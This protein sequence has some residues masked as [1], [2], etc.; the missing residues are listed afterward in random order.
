MSAQANNLSGRERL[1]RR[2]LAGAAAILMGVSLVFTGST[3][4]H[5]IDLLKARESAREYARRVRDNSGGKYLHYS[6][7]CRAM[8]PGHNH[9]VSCVIDYQNAKDKAAGVYTCRE[10]IKIYMFPHSVG[11]NYTL[12]G[13]HSSNNNCGGYFVKYQKMG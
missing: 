2:V 11:L 6:T 12:V 7:K 10:S 8:F 13:D 9:Y 4:A 3:S 5:D 1:R